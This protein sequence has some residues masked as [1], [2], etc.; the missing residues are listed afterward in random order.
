MITN[1]L[2]FILVLLIAALLLAPLESL[3]WWATRG[4]EEVDRDGKPSSKLVAG[5]EVVAS[6][7]ESQPD[8][9]APETDPGAGTHR[10]F[11]VYLSGIG[12]IGASDVPEEEY[13]FVEDLKTNLTSF[14]VID[15]VFPYAVDNRG[16]TAER[17]LGRLW[18][19][20]ETIRLKNPNALLA[21]LINLRN[22]MQMLVCADRRY[23]PTYNMGTAGEIYRSLV[24]HGHRP[25]A[26]DEVILYGWSG[27]GQIA[28]GAAW[29]L[30][31][32][33]LK[34]SV[35]SMGGMLSDDIALA[36]IGHLWHLFGTRDPVQALGPKMFAGR[37]PIAVSSPWNEAIRA[38]KITMWPVGP[39]HHNVKEHYFDRENTLPDGRTYS[40]TV[41]DAVT[42][43]L[44]HDRLPDGEPATPLNQ[45]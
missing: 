2:A 11:L 24:R 19:R 5:K 30:D 23:G 31:A 12:A 34:V 18:R 44:E 21:V 17:M 41:I 4:A 40:Q 36:R 10:R 22:T 3:Y 25:G 32:L 33:G 42:G 15:D 14:V 28:L 7:L 13:P 43:I 16:L 20:L 6:I 35:L 37:W 38:G 9:E 39:F 1:L 45:P 26:A 8:A 29:Y 27:G